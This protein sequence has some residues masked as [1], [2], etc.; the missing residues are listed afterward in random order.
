MEDA[1]AAANPDH[2]YNEVTGKRKKIL[3]KEEGVL[4]VNLKDLSPGMKVKIVDAWGT[5]CYVN[6]E[7]RMDRHLGTIVTIKWVSDVFACIEEDVGEGTYGD[8]KN[9]EWYPNTFDYIVGNESP[10]IEPANE[11]EIRSFIFENSEEV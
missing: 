4:V 11:S 1:G 2:L 5:R 7:G 9:W 8:N 3:G 6:S 10:D